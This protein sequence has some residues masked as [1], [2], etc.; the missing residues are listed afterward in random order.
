M[1][2]IMGAEHKFEE[3]WVTYEQSLEKYLTQSG[4]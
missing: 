2:Y 4:K 1:K 3:N